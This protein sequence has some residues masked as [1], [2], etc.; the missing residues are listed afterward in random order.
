MEKKNTT[1]YTEAGYQ[2]LLDELAYLEGEKTEEV[3]KAL[4]FARSLGDLTENSE[5][6]A[7]KDEQAQ[8]EARKNELKELIKNAEIIDESEI[9]ENVANLGSTILLLDCE[10]NEEVEYSIVS[11][12]EADPMNGCISDRSPIGAAMVGKTVG[13]VVDVETPG[14][15]VRFKVLKVERTKH[16][17]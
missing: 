14:G 4:A 9:D 13:D 2:A 16:E 11:T 1:K 5:Y 7:A 3:K 6:D 15:I 17:E 12:N 10:Y 8:V